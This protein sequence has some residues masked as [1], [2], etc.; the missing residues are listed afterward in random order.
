MLLTGLVW[1][2]PASLALGSSVPTLAT[3]RD[4]LALFEDS[5]ILN[6]IAR[7]KLPA[8]NIWYNENMGFLQYLQE[9]EIVVARL[10]KYDVWTGEIPFDLEYPLHQTP[11]AI[12]M[13]SPLP[14]ISTETF[15]VNS[16]VYQQYIDLILPAIASFN[17]TA[18]AFE[19]STS[20][21][22]LLMADHNLMSLIS[23]RIHYGK[24]VAETKYVNNASIFANVTD[25]A[26][27]EALLT[28]K[29]QESVVKTRSEAKAKYLSA[30]LNFNSTTGALLNSSKGA[31]DPRWVG[32]EL[33]GRILIP[34]T[35]EVEVQ[36]ILSRGG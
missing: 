19:N 8:S 31:F 1:S 28:D 23:K 25:R 30:H 22:T 13:V 3:I 10:G 9:L 29:A 24:V 21:A 36:Y 32:Q 11:F 26:M 35:T 18:A 17:S 6:L 15:S 14:S 2:L 5:I 33:F 7:T 27:V 16:A 34:T 4:T 12:N 20:L